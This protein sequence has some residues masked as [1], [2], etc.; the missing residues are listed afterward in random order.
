MGESSEKKVIAH[1]TT[2]TSDFIVVCAEGTF[3]LGLDEGS[4]RGRRCWTEIILL[5]LHLIHF[6]LLFYFE[7]LLQLLPN[8]FHSV[9]SQRSNVHDLLNFS[10]LFHWRGDAEL[11]FSDDEVIVEMLPLKGEGVPT[12]RSASQQINCWN[13]F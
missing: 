1:F 3:D 2:V 7:N 9:I 11:S 13:A 12:V 10:L 5:L 6:L 4:F 8:H